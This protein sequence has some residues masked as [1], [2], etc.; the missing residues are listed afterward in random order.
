MKPCEHSH[1]LSIQSLK[2]ETI[3]FET[4]VLRRLVNLL[5]DPDRQHPILFVLIG[6]AAKARALEELDLGVKLRESKSNKPCGDLHLYHDS[7][8]ID[9][10]SPV[11]VADG[12]LPFRARGGRLLTSKTC[13]SLT[14]R[15]LLR[16]VE[17]ARAGQLDDLANCL[18]SRLI[19][20][21][22]NVF[23]I[24][25]ADCGGIKPLVRRLV[26]WFQRSQSSTIPNFAPPRLLIVVESKTVTGRVETF[27][28][29]KILKLLKEQTTNESLLQFW[30]FEVL[31]SHPGVSKS[32]RGLRERLMNLSEQ[33][34]REKL[35]TQTLFSARHFEAFFAPACTHFAEARNEPFNFISTTRSQNPVST[36]LAEHLS[37]FLDRI[38][39]SQD[40]AGFAALTIASS[41]L[42]DNYPPDTHEF[43]PR[44]VFRALYKD[45]CSEASL[46]RNGSIRSIPPGSLVQLIEDSLVDCF[47]EFTQQGSVP[48]ADIHRAHIGAFRTLWRAVYSDQT[49]LMCLRRTPEFI[50]PCG[51]FFCE[52]CV[53]IFG[54]ETL[55]SRWTYHVPSCFLCGVELRNVRFKVK[56]DTAGVVVLSID[57]GGIRGRGPLQTLQLL[58]GKVPYPIQEN[59]DVVYGTSCV[60]ALGMFYNGWSVER[61]A[62]IFEKTAREAFTPRKSCC[63]PLISWPYNLIL[64]YLRGVYPASNIERALKEAFGRETSI[65][66]RPHASAQGVKIGLPVITFPETMPCI[67]T[68][69][70]GKGRRAEDCGYKAIRPNDRR[71]PVWEMARGA[72]AAPWYFT[73]FWILGVGPVEDGGQWVN[74]PVELALWEISVIWPSIDEPD[75]VISLGTGSSKTQTDTVGLIHPRRTWRW[76]VIP[77]LYHTFMWSISGKKIWQE[78]RNRHRANPRAQYFRFDA[79]FEG[80]EPALDNVS[81]MEEVAAKVRMQLTDAPEIEAAAQCLTATRFFFEL[82]SMPIK[83][84][85]HYEGAGYI[86]CRLPCKSVPFQDLLQQLKDSSARFLLDGHPITTRL[87]W[88]ASDPDGIFRKRIVFKVKAGMAITLQR[89]GFPPRHIS[90]SPFSVV[91]LINAQGLNAYFGRADHKKRK[92]GGDVEERPGKRQRVER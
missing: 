88:S 85:D 31:I 82:E 56:P 53:R 80:A 90:G 81:R 59:V 70:V 91:A 16:T 9:S 72:T 39:S 58:Q 57:G 78:F 79:E 60:S 46:F 67:F 49:C 21:F 4:S 20:P 25:A 29:K 7:S 77:R 55:D 62:E 66:E 83:Y 54:D 13:H 86:Y 32:Y 44:Q 30:T 22:A 36:D 19:A 75:V 23:C 69:Y 61:C 41:F 26:T 24:F 68:N 87:D 14:P 5:P 43:D 15:T 89:E 27:M 38:E 1:W 6:S 76:G 65:L 52:T 8:S 28:T 45:A 3:L 84:G 48:A 37:R 47:L 33:S 64:S 11:F 10:E 71:T 73:P 2:H 35:N 12:V 51:H 92:R 34:Q 50:L 42:L 17:R 40:L 18:Y 63:I 74:N